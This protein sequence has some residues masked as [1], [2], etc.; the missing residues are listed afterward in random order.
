MHPS[1]AKCYKSKAMTPR[2]SSGERL[3]HPALLTLFHHADVHAALQSACLAVA[4]VVL[5][6]G[7]TAIEG[8]RE[9]GLALH[10]A[11]EGEANS[12]KKYLK[13]PQTN[14]LKKKKTAK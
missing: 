8:T 2:R 13:K 11:S 7:A 3:P 6:D 14:T 1:L 12:I 5:G 9:G 4:P 10:A